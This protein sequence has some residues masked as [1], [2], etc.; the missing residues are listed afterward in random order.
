MTADTLN[1]HL[2]HG[3][4][5]QVTTYSRSVLYRAQHAGCFKTGADGNLYVKR[6]KSWDCLSI[7]SGQRL[8]VG[9]RLGRESHA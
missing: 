4:V 3:G 8:L 2:T 1:Q 5:V 9:I 6:G 7:E